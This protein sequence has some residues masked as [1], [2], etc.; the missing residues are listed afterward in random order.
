MLEFISLYE[1]L[2]NCLIDLSHLRVFGCVISHVRSLHHDKLNLR[3][4]KCIFMG[5]FSTQRR[6]KCFN[7][8]TNKMFVSI[9]VKFEEDSPYFTQDNNSSQDELLGDLFSLPNP[10]HYKHVCHHEAQSLTHSVLSI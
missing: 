10:S 9:N 7:P 5:Y 3:V 6:Y 4:V 1:V 2:K 8:I